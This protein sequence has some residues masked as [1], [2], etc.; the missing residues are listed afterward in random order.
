MPKYTIEPKFDYG[1][2]VCKLSDPDKYL[3]IVISFLVDRKDVLYQ[4]R[5]PGLEF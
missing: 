2:H 4:V 5:G 1:A 3:Y